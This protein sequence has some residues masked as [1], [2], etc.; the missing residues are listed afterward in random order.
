M[1]M[2][3][4]EWTYKVMPGEENHARATA[5]GIIAEV[6]GKEKGCVYCSQGARYGDR[7]S[8]F[9]ITDYMMRVYEAGKIVG[10]YEIRRCPICG[11][12]LK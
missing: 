3:L 10:V 7:N 9:T 8:W 6:L 4:I 5:A 2:R 1:D 12:H 11:R